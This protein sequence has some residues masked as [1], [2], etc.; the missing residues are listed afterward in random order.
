MFDF[1]SA[2]TEDLT[3]GP[4]KA[5]VEGRV[6]LLDHRWVWMAI[7]V[8][9]A[10]VLIRN[11]ALITI[12]GFMLVI[13]AFAWNWNRHALDG[14]R[15]RRRFHHRRAFPAEQVEVQLLVENP[16]LLP[17]TWL[18][19]EDEW[20]SEFGT[21]D[22]SILAPS[23]GPA[24][25]Y[26]VNVY[27]LRWYERV[28]RRYLLVARQRGIYPTGPAHLVSGDPFGLFEDD[29]TLDKTDLLVVYPQ[30]IPLEALGLNAQDPF[31]DIRAQQRLYEDPS[32][33]MGVRDHRPNDSFRHIHWQA[34]ARMGKLQVRQYE[35]TRTQSLVLCLNI[36]SFDDYVR[37]VWPEM[38]E[39]AISV[40]ASIA[41]W[42][43][44]QDYAVGLVANATLTQTDRPLRT[45][46]SRSRDQLSNL[47]EAMAGIT[48][49]VTSEYARFLLQES[50]RM[51]WGATI[52]A[53]TGF[54][55]DAIVSSL[56]RLRQR[57]RKS[58]LIA[59]EK[60]PPPAVPEILT[61]HLPIAEAE[62]ETETAPAVSPE[63]ETPR[64][65][66]LR[67]RAERESPIG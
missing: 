9:I 63:E 43:V 60:T 24:I 54:V 7:I 14:I 65:R 41:S 32:R 15:Y 31:G 66:Y 16:K 1:E 10:G 57:G 12:T 48:Y 46:P 52:V 22:E 30:V 6:N 26:L 64:Q 29:G 23:S 19:V 18:Q 56:L 33:I 25:G 17:V 58:V 34:T 49:F 4:S 38:V 62:P 5:S 55:N 51:P 13:V 37:G 40:A 67:Q 2:E 39:Y 50:T 21:V 3:K 8:F 53:I 47:L 28:R 59:L 61:Y 11:T 45:Q 44:E 35:P 36:A 27:S 42:A 20:P